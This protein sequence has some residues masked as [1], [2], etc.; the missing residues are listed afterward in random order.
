MIPSDVDANAA[1]RALEPASR[2]ANGFKARSA[3]VAMRELAMGAMRDGKDCGAGASACW[4][5]EAQSGNVLTSTYIRTSPL[6]APALYAGRFLS[7]AENS[8]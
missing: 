2:D 4:R 7:K 3:L 5:R 6:R 8:K 1:L